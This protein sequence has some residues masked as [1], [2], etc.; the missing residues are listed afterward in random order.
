MRSTGVTSVGRLFF[1]GSKLMTRISLEE[2]YQLDYEAN[3]TECKRDGE[4]FRSRHHDGLDPLVSTSQ[5]RFRFVGLLLLV[6]PPLLGD[7]SL[8]CA[9]VVDLLAAENLF[10]VPRS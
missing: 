3:R 4:R 5:L 7:G 8:E 6:R 1:S 9:L 2:H 10:E